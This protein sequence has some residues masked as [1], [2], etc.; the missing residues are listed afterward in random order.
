MTLQQQIWRSTDAGLEQD[1]QAYKKA[2]EENRMPAMIPIWE[3]TLQLIEM[4]I[5]V[6]MKYK[7]SPQAT[8]QEELPF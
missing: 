5:N 8:N 4:Q 1:R 2:I 6:R 3:Y 7:Q